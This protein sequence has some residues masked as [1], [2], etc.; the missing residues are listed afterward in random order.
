[1]GRVDSGGEFSI[2][3]LRTQFIILCISCKLGRATAKV[4]LGIFDWIGHMKRLRLL[5]YSL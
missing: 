1:M 3:E 5:C 2:R 4:A